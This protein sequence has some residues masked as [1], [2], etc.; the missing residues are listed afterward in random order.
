[1]D[2]VGQ[3]QRALQVAR[4][5]HT[6]SIAALRDVVRIRSLTGEE[7]N[8][9]RHIAGLLRAIGAE[10]TVAEPDVA[11]MFRKFPRIA[12]YPTHWQHDLI[13]PYTELP[14]YEA[15]TASGLQ[16]VLNYTD[17][18]NVTGV[19]RGT[20]GGRSLILNGHIDTVT[21][22]PAKEWTRDPFGAEIVDGAMYGR[23]TSDMKGG[24]MAALMALTYLAETGKRPRG[25]VIF[26][27]VVNEEH[28]GNGTLDL[29]V[30]GQRADAAIV[31]EPTSNTI[32]TVARRTATPMNSI[33]RP[34]SVTVRTNGCP[35]LMPTAARNN[36]KP[37]LRRTTL[38]GSGITQRT[39]RFAF[40]VV[41]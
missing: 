14:T 32:A 22:E 28:A 27:C 10:A 17:R 7:G 8:A 16:A 15:L 21:I 26:Q 4:G 23:G 34:V 13:L 36:A 30:R 33:V 35:A 11:A 37:K 25:D 40:D 38:A 19:V 2:A 1:M 29:V 20:G 9:Q 3:P 6:R 12:Q 24:V 5:S 18:P 31:L 41:T 39:K